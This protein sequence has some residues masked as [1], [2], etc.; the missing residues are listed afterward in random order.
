MSEPAWNRKPGPAGGACGATH[1]HASG[2]TV[3]HCGHPTANWP[4]YILTP[5]GET[6]LAPNGRGFK[7]LADAKHEVERLTEKK[8][9]GRNP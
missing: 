3:R 7:Y 9:P 1:T 5:D 4:Y 2:H 6:V 8:N